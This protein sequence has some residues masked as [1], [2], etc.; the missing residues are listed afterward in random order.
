M[1]RDSTIQWTHATFNP[2]RGCT[3]ISA[4]CQHCYA[5]ALSKRNPK[6]LGEW[7]PNGVRVIASPAYWRKP[8]AWD[9]EA[10]TTGQRLRVFCASLADVF[11]DRP[12]LD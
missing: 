11:E 5:E 3:K 9:R 7:G 4:G 1:G 12:E 10:R 2:W 6:T 8:V